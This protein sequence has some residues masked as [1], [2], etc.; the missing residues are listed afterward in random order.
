MCVAVARSAWADHSP[1][2][3]TVQH[4]ATNLS[5]QAWLPSSSVIVVT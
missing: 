3:I 2:A 1:L 5:M 4:T